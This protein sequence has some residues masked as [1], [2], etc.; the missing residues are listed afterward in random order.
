MNDY[1]SEKANAETKMFCPA[2]G[3]ECRLGQNYCPNCGSS[4]NVG[5]F[6]NEQIPYASAQGPYHQYSAQEHNEPRLA[7]TESDLAYFICDNQAYYRNKFAKM[8]M[9]NSKVSWNWCSFL[10]GTFWLAYRKMYGLCAAAYFIPLV[11][12]N[13]LPA[14]VRL[15]LSLI[16]WI[17]FGL[18]GNY[19]YMRHAEKHIL[20][21][22]TMDDNS[23]KYYY[24]T[25]GG[26]SGRSLFIY[27]V[28]IFVFAF[29]GEFI[30][31]III[32]LQ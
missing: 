4:L 11:C 31:N 1:L 12:S 3:G 17:C 10:F 27:I 7:V 8:R 6:Q 26:T 14:P 13:L 5:Q 15:L 9:T 28:L 21:G 2:C 24:I 29:L 25:K 30:K 22:K 19:A 20:T 18:F 16:L 23:K 32:S